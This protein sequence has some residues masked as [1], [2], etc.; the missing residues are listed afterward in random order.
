MKP[1]AAKGRTPKKAATKKAKAVAGSV[2][3]SVV[4]AK[5]NV[6]KAGRK[7]LNKAAKEEVDELLEQTATNGG[8]AAAAVEGQNVTVTPSAS[9]KAVAKAQVKKLKSMVSLKSYN[10]MEEEAATPVRKSERL[11]ATAE[12]AEAPEANGQNGHH[13]EEDAA[14]PKTPV[15]MDI[16]TAEEAVE[17]NGTN[18]PAAG[19]GFFK[20]TMSRIWKLPA[21]AA[22]GVAYQDINGQQTNGDGAAAAAGA[23]EEAGKS[24]SKRDSCVIS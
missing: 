16:S 4:K 20:K 7:K 13:E 6:V 22:A 2:K 11:R 19:P 23:Q 21:D 8:G 18:A 9:Q 17:T 24:T 10:K 14:V 5:A 3:K 1:Y 12:D 15:M